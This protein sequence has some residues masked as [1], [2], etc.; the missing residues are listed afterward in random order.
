MVKIVNKTKQLKWARVEVIHSVSPTP[1][2]LLR[3]KD[4]LSAS[5]GIV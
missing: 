1:S 3:P 5:Q 2:P 4:T